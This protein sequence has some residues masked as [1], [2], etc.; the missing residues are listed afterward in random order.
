M[1]EIE[2]KFLNINPNK[3][4][5]K[6]ADIGAS[7]VGEYFQRW[8]TFDYS[9]WRLDKDGAWIRLRDEGDGKI[10]LTYKKRLGM[11]SRDGAVNDAG[12]E[13]VEIE[14]SDFLKTASIFKQAG[15]IEKHY[16]EK[17]RI[18]WIKDDIIFDIDTYPALDPY[19]EIE[20]VSWEKIDEAMCLLNF[21]PEEKKIFSANQVYAMKG[22]DVG[23]LQRITFD[24]GLIE[25]ERKPHTL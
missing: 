11:K 7:K 25:R 19:L 9:D 13:E 16:A 3:L 8:K 14:V 17:K 18:R 23:R 15:F 22:I 5:K 21:G 20:T 24:E 2:V 12:M 6:L 10:T 1:Q 4:Q